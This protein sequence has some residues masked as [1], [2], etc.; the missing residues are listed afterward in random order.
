MRTHEITRGCQ[1]RE[2]H[3]RIPHTR[4]HTRTGFDMPFD[5]LLTTDILHTHH[6]VSAHSSTKDSPSPSH[7]SHTHTHPHTHTLRPPPHTHTLR[8]HTPAHSPLGVC[9][10]LEEGQPFAHTPHHLY[11]R[12]RE[13]GGIDGTH[14]RHGVAQ[15]D[16]E[17]QT[18]LQTPRLQ[19]HQQQVPADRAKSRDTHCACVQLRHVVCSARLALCHVTRAHVCN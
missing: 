1:R 11:G 6:S 5:V 7:P 3:A 2:I 10:Q 16:A 12:L 15:D 17:K 8:P 4:K 19:H 14:D 9:P 13:A 18:P